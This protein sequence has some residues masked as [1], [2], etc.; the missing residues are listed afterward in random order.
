MGEVCVFDVG[1]CASFESHHGRG[2][3]GGA[4]PVDG[5]HAGGDGGRCDGVGP[6]D[7]V[8]AIDDAVLEGAPE[9]PVAHCGCWCQWSPIEK[10]GQKRKLVS[11][12]GKWVRASRWVS[13]F[14]LATVDPLPS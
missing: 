10:W 4:A 5:K 1:E 6:H 3:H 12:D 8:A 11:P 9:G 13:T 7:T 14:F 2:G